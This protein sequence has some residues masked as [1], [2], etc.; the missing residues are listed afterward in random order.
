ML[1]IQGRNVND[2]WHTAKQVMKEHG[3]PRE[4]R[5][6]PV[7][8]VAEPVTTCYFAPTERVLFDP[9]RD[10]NP[11]FHF[12]EAMWMLSG[13]ND[14]AWICQFLPRFSQYSDD[15]KTFHG[16]Y[17]YRWR[18]HFGQDQ[19]HA[20][21][22]MLIE[23]N[24]NRRAVIGHWDVNADLWSPEAIKLRGSVPKDLPCNTTIYVKVRDGLLHMTV[25]NRSNDVC[26]GCYGANVVHMS[27][28]QEYLSGM[29]GVKVGPY[30]QV[31]DSWHAYLETWNKQNLTDEPYD[32]PYE[33]SANRGVWSY[34]CVTH[35][36]HFDRDLAN[37]MSFTEP[38][39][40]HDLS[41][42]G[43]INPFFYEVALPMYSAWW[44]WKEKNFG[45]AYRQL[46]KMPDNVDWQVAAREWLERRG[47]KT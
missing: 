7:L 9:V 38:N 35:P 17:G 15:G 23:D 44:S 43:Y 20:I 6:G 12:L 46:N 40:P 24:T 13:R 3:V 14:V 45:E 21:I 16:A 31:S 25:C 37:F 18:N 11:F 1:I 32:N 5:N 22:S 10:A 26:L 27:F 29:I 36:V 42:P 41:S 2:T 47:K 4:S 33:P 34:P 39:S 30:H 19:L 8:E 28:L